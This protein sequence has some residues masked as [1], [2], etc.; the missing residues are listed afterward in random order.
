ME[1]SF[2]EAS[3]I[4]VYLGFFLSA[5]LIAQT[6]N[7][8]QRFAEGLALA[9]L[10]IAVLGLGSRLLPDLITVSDPSSGGPRLRYPLGYWNANGALFGFGVALLLWL[11]VN[12]SSKAFRWAALAFLPVLLLALYFTYSRGGVLAMAIAVLVFLAMSEDRLVHAVQLCLTLLA[13]A[14]PVIATQARRALADNLDSPEAA[15]DGLFVL[16]LLLIG[17]ALLLGATWVLSRLAKGKPVLVKRSIAI[18]RHPRLLAVLG[19]CLALGAL[20]AVVTIGDRAW[21]QFSSPDLQFPERPETH[22][23]QLSGAGRHDFWRVALEGFQEAP[24]LGTGAGTYGFT[25]RKDRSIDLPVQDAHSI[26]LEPLSELGLLGAA[27]FIAMIVILLG[28]GLAAWR[29]E[30]RR[31]RERTAVLIAVMVAFVA[32]A[33]FDWFWEMAAL[34]AVFFLAAGVVV[35]SRC[36]QLSRFPQADEPSYDEGRRYGFA[37][38]GVALAWIAIAMLAGPLAMKFELSRSQDAAAEGRIASAVDHALTARS[39]QPWAA[40]PY[41]QLGG[42]AELEGAHEIA[43]EHYHQARN[44]ERENWQIWYLS[45][46]AAEAAGDIEAAQRYLERAQEL[47]PRAPEFRDQE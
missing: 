9:I 18:S 22:F 37:I 32:S 38:S 5:L 44:R 25:W 17:I 16:L 34:G 11:R 24:V 3:R 33:G 1:R 19:V 46:R 30:L 41:I 6:E 27:L 14:P 40:S 21:E 36:S 2:N 13:T 45:G 42:L 26:L 8:R 43:L 47:N 4:L 29:R 31:A 20:G 7:L 15:S 12:G 10:V 39:L 35:G 28:V 23:S